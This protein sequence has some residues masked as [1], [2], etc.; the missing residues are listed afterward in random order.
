MD[1]EQVKEW[2]AAGSTVELE[3][4][5]IKAIARSTEQDQL[6]TMGSVL[7]LLVESGRLDFAETLGWALLADGTERL[8]P[9]D[10]LEI[11]KVVVSSVPESDELR[12]LTGELYKQLYADNEHF[13]SIFRNAGLMGRQSPRRALRTLDT[14]LALKSGMYLANR[15]DNRVIRMRAYDAALGEFEVTGEGGKL[16]HMEPKALADEFDI[17]AETDFRVLCRH[18]PEELRAMLDKDPG[19]VLMGICMSSGG[20]ID[21]TSLK[22]RLVPDHLPKEKWSGWWNRARTAVK[23]SEY[24]ALE[25][26]NP[27]VVRYYP[28]GRSLEEHFAGAARDA[29]MPLEHLSVLQQYAKDARHRKQPLEASFT[30][31]IVE[32]LAEQVRSF[33]SK[34][35][36]NALSAALAI[37]AAVAMGVSPPQGECPSAAQILSEATNAAQV[38]SQLE[39]VSLWPAAMEALAQ[40][41]DAEANFKRLLLTAPAALIDQV[42]SHLS[43]DARTGVIAE[44]VSNAISNPVKYLDICIWLWKGP[45]RPLANAP[46]KLELLTR[47][48]SV[49]QEVQRDWDADARTRKATYQKIRS[50]ISSQEFAAYRQA[51]LEMDEP[52]AR[53][54]KTR[55]ERL[56]GLAETARHQM[57]DILRENFFAIFQVE[58]VAPWLD[59]SAIW[60]SQKA[61]HARQAELTELTYVK[62]L[63][64]SRAIGRAAEH[65]DLSENAEWKFAIEE[66]N[67]LKA[68]A[69]KIQQELMQARVI[70]P[71]DVP[72]DSVA[73][74][75]RVRLKRVSDG[76][77]VEICFLGPWDTNVRNRVLSYRTPIAQALMGKS[78]G[79]TVLL[80]LDGGEETQYTIEQ[81]GP[82]PQ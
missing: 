11:A 7:V 1:M 68:R 22:D 37:E 14:C 25:G 33:R 46:G 13:E 9:L 82:A 21:A 15:Y 18:R 10:A 48:L 57:L 52:I 55:I 59:E 54:I 30:N 45:D 20:S 78:L 56:D 72:D 3:A 6:E 26:R 64:N 81:V 62:M 71:E 60:T 43:E 8:A 53:T 16:L 12:S 69:S 35:P 49:I 27:A 70:H 74:G 79:E 66:Q 31:P 41:P 50:A 36:A 44:A 63:E 19:G 34:R 47:M 38:I 28:K 17:T 77:D 51:V 32:T 76:W 67:R 58:K 2:I 23:R 65:G 42:I 29:R 39:D 5:W 24:L 75:S 61:L 73:I 80:K 40:R 4:A